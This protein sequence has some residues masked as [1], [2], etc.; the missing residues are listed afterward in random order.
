MISCFAEANGLFGMGPKIVFGAPGGIRLVLGLDPSP[1]KVSPDE[2]HGQSF[3][4]QDRFAEWRLLKECKQEALW[5][6][7]L[8][9]GGCFALAFRQAARR[10][11]IASHTTIGVPLR[12]WVIGGIFSFQL[13][14]ALYGESCANKAV[15]RLPDSELA[16][17]ILRYRNQLPETKPNRSCEANMQSA[18]TSSLLDSVPHPD[19]EPAGVWNWQNLIPDPKETVAEDCGLKL[20]KTIKTYAEL[21]QENRKIRELIAPSRP[22]SLY[23]KLRMQNREEAR[24]A[25]KTDCERGEW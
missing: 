14:Y 7:V 1:R 16:A 9:L 11:L 22:V 21:R 10:G 24:N 12:F 4:N 18:E 13:G 6:R 3:I 23:D 15:V 19:G 17:N 8:P 5:S 25:T 2:G 20:S